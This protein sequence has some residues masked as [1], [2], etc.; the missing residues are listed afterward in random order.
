MAYGLTDY[1]PDFSYGN[2]KSDNRDLTIPDLPVEQK[3]YKY[4]MVT[5]F[6]ALYGLFEPRDVPTIKY[7]K[8]KCLFKL[9]YCIMIKYLKARVRGWVEVFGINNIE[10]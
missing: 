4:H 5:G 10:Y 9:P 8:K 2:R 1:F 6:Q 7:K 3:Y